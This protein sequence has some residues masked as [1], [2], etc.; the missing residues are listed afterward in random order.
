MDDLIANMTK[1]QDQHQVR[2]NTSRQH[3]WPIKQ[4]MSRGDGHHMATRPREHMYLLG[5]HGLGTKGATYRTSD[6][7]FANRSSVAHVHRTTS[8]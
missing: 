6:S 5:M 1:V 2:G 4:I 8:T 7:E 3:A